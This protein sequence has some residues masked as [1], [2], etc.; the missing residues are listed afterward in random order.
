MLSLSCSAVAGAQSGAPSGNAQR[1]VV[2][3]V[4]AAADTGQSFALVL[5][6]GYTPAKRWP[7]LFVFDPRGR[8]LLGAERFADA[9]DRLG[10]VIASSYDSRSDSSPEVNVRAM[11]AML[12]SVQDRVSVD[13]RRMYLA[14]FSGTARQIWEFAVELRAH[15]AG[16]IGFGAGIPRPSDALGAALGGD[17]TFAFF[18][19]A[20]DEDFN[21]SETRAFWTHLRLV[22]IPSRF[23]EYAGPHA[24]PAAAVCGSALEWMQARAMLAGR[25]PID[26]AFLAG[27][28]AAEVDSARSLERRGQRARAAEA[29]RASADD[30]AGWAEGLDAGRRADLLEAGTDVKDFRTRERA[31]AQREGER[32]AA[33]E[34]AFLLMRGSRQVGTV[35]EVLQRLGAAELEREATSADSLTSRSARRLLARL[36]ASL[37]FYEPRAYLARGAP[38][39]ALVMLAA[40]ARLGMLEGESCALLARARAALPGGH[41]ELRCRDR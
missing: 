14:G 15:V 30:Y 1:V 8:A 27:R 21:F 10:Y 31:L 38:R 28:L 9:A 35:E 12:E 2:A 4:V 41:A 7:V 6:S 39:E 40:A 13:M 34:R 20:G 26:S 25:I 19:G 24:W 32:S 29:Y 23:A 3:R 16:V 36:R 5:P 37:G 18:G 22:R 11:N 33:L 17:R